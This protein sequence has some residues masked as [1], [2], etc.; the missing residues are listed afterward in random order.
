[1]TPI[2]WNATDL[3]PGVRDFRIKWINTPYLRNGAVEWSPLNG[4]FTE[5]GNF[6]Q[7]VNSPITVRAPKLATQPISLVNSVS[8]DVFSKQSLSAPAQELIITHPNIR[9]VDG[10]VIEGREFQVVYPDAIMEGVDLAVGVW[11][12]RA[13]RAEHLYVIRSMP[14]GRGPI[15]IESEI[16]AVGSKI[17][18]WDRKQE[19]DVATD[20][21]SILLNQDERRGWSLKKPIAW[22]YTDGKIVKTA[23]NAKIRLQKTG[24]VVI[25]KIIPRELVQTAL[26]A[27]SELRCDLTGTFYPDANPETTS[28]DGA[29]D[30]GTGTWTTL[31]D[32]TFSSVYDS[33]ADNYFARFMCG[34]G[35]SYWTL[36][37]SL[38]LFDT[39]TLGSSA[40]IT[41]ATLSFYCIYNNNPNPGAYVP[42]YCIYG[43]TTVSNSA[44][45]S[46][47]FATTQ[48]TELSNTINQP[49]FPTNTYNTF[50][51]N[52]NGRAAINKTGVSKF[53]FK[54]AYHD[55]G[56]V[57]PTPNTVA[58][59]V[60]VHG[61]HAETSG[62]TQDPKLVVTYEAAVAA[63]R[64]ALLG[65]G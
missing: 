9:P 31:L 55:V 51:F 60:Y 4:S 32:R 2:T 35:T 42:I 23:I 27:G 8:Y 63:H 47:D 36:I 33:D 65:V 1:M 39:S 16:T 19:L 15:E 22:Y 50:T 48:S 56:R 17:D 25:R 64:L 14:P 26:D 43:A 57:A 20:K 10:R 59:N 49:S 13:P 24:T 44:L 61:R 37:R 6:W 38:Y 3:A 28:V 53:S 58:A 7:T 40:S 18:K 30:A 52:S 11:H 54:D 41:D 12:G 5:D 62:T 46:G 45:S 21:I 34:G 29:L